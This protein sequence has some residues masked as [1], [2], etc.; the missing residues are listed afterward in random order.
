MHQ[1]NDGHTVLAFGHDQPAGECYAGSLKTGLKNIEENT[2]AL[3]SVK[4]DLARSTVAE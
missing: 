2:V 3:H 1:N 4:V